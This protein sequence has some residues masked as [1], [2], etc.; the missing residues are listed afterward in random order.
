MRTE[1]LLEKELDLVL[2]LLTDQNRLVMR[3]CLTTGLRVGDA[4][5]LKPHQLKP[6]VWITETKTRKRRQIG[7]PA[8]LLSDLRAHAGEHWVFPG[9][10]P[11]KHLTRQAVWKD[12]KRA[13]SAC[14]LSQNIGPH[15]MRKVWAVD[16][17]KKY[18]DLEKVQRAMRHDDVCVTMLYAMADQQLEAKNKRRR[19]AAGRRMS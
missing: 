9:R 18:G 11:A 10:D 19:A 5:S 1:Y 7:F 2:M 15:S 8:P 13:A 4:L 14:R 12:V 6:N 16:L 3:T 17:L